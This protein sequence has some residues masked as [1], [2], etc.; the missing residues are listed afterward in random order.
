[1][2]V[3]IEEL[4]VLILVGGKGTRLRS[5]VSDRPKPMAEVAG[6]PFVEVL[7]K[8]LKAQG[9]KR[10]TFCTGYMSEAIANYFGDG[11][12]WEMNIQ[13]SPESIPL[14]TAGA[15]RNALDKISSNP[16]LVM[17]GDSYCRVDIRSLLKF[18]QQKK[19]QAS[20]WLVPGE[21]CRRYGSVAIDKQG[22]VQAFGEKMPEK[23][24][25]LI[26]AGAYILERESVATLP[27]GCPVSMETEFFPQLIGNGLYGVVG[28][29]SLLD[30]GT[31]ESYALAGQF[32]AAES[33]V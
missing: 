24:A 6:V 23:V 5:V 21:D 19:A 9:I 20:L 2:T 3:E 16:F 18:H 13:Y 17:N 31:P 11:S 7:L 26:N 8:I 10:I 4:D 30:I 32:L 27:Q 22:V 1:M 15:V 25:G 33:W 12:Q 28:E 14:G 29:S